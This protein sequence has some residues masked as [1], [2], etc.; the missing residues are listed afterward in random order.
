[1]SRPFH[2]LSGAASPSFEGARITSLRRLARP[3]FT[4]GWIVG[5]GAMGGGDLETGCGWIAGGSA[6]TGWCECTLRKPAKNYWPRM[7]ANQRWEHKVK[8]LLS[9]VLCLVMPGGIFAADNGYK[10]P[11]DGVGALMALT[12]SR[13]HFVGLTWAIWR[14]KG[15]L[16]SEALTVKN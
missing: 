2:N 8:R 6:E 11:Y 5:V 7:N 10:V 1:M 3:G 15:R 16:D 13:K 4:A 14:T 12:K 9:V